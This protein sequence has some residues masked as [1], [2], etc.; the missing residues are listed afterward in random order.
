MTSAQHIPCPKQPNCLWSTCDGQICN[1]CELHFC[2]WPGEC[3]G[4][5]KVCGGPTDPVYTHVDGRIT[6]DLTAHGATNTIHAACCSK[7]CCDAHD[8]ISD[9]RAAADGISVLRP[10]EVTFEQA[11]E[12]FMQ[13]ELC[14]EGVGPRRPS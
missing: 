6:C 5:C 1:V 11:N 2:K 12:V 7:A 10:G 13:N 9:T 4:R 14:L 3:R 8:T